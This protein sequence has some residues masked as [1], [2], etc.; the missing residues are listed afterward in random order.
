MFAPLPRCDVFYNIT[1]LVEIV[2]GLMQIGQHASGRFIS[3]FDGRLQD[4]LKKY[5]NYNTR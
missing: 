4:T 3:D 1:N 5:S 2:K